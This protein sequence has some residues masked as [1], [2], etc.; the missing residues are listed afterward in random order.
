MTQSL[1]QTSC[2]T[3]L[4]HHS[5]LWPGLKAIG[6]GL[7]AVAQTNLFALLVSGLIFGLM[8][9]SGGLLPIIASGIVLTTWVG[10]YLLDVVSI[11][12]QDR[13]NEKN[14]AV[15]KL[16]DLLE[17]LDSRATKTI[18]LDLTFE[19]WIEHKENKHL[20]QARYVSNILIDIA[21]L[22][23][24]LIFP[25]VVNRIQSGSTGLSIMSAIGHLSDSAHVIDTVSDLREKQS[26][27]L[28]KKAVDNIRDNKMKLAQHMRDNKI[29]LDQHM[30]DNKIKLNK[31]MQDNKTKPQQNSYT[32]SL[33]EINENILKVSKELNEKVQQDVNI[34]ARNAI[35]QSNS[36]VALYKAM[37]K[38]AKNYTPPSL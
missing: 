14:E 9:A 36:F 34:I 2:T 20:V 10:K 5:A 33:N 27:E 24:F 11:R 4:T 21:A 28:Q 35:K 31:H 3:A 17:T 6:K 19:H 26:N 23:Q 13:I 22:F 15:Q 12:V 38:D 29:K 25:N 30:Q 18:K 1:A 32:K 8:I 7:W 37:Y 16:V